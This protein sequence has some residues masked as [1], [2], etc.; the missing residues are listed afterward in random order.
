MLAIFQIK[1][2]HTATQMQSEG[3]TEHNKSA[4]SLQ[5]SYS[6][7]HPLTVGNML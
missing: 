5:A 3:L 7:S 1:K 6:R 2:I 4:Y